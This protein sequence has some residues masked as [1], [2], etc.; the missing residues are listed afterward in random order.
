[1]KYSIIGTG[2]VAL[3]LVTMLS[4]CGHQ[5]LQVYGRQ[6]SEAQAIA[7]VGGGKITLSLN[8]ISDENDLI[9][10]AVSDDAIKEISAQLSAKIPVVHTSGNTSMDILQQNIRGV[11]WPLFSFSKIIKINYDQIPFLIEA[12]DD[13]FKK[14]L[15]EVFEKISGKVYSISSEERKKVHLAAVF[16]NNF[17]N[18]LMHLSD[19]ILSEIPLPFDVLMPMIK[20]QIEAADQTSLL[21]SQTGPARRNDRITIED[22]LKMIKDNDDLTSIYTSITNS[23]LKT[24]H[25]KKL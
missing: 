14:M 1:M 23:I 6:K 9:F 17:T 24:Y 13:V 7:G 8:D 2:N 19:N 25:E 4:G 3:H 12:S 16:A 5:L 18:H 15:S 10:I 11:V 20:N 22:H 21:E